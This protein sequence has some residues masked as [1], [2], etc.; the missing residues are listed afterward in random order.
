MSTQKGDEPILQGEQPASLQGNSPTLQRN[1]D[2]SL[3]RHPPTLRLAAI[4]FG[5]IC[6]LWLTHVYGLFFFGTSAYFSF[7]D[8]ATLSFKNIHILGA[9]VRLLLPVVV[10]FGLARLSNGLPLTEATVSAFLGA[11]L[12]CWPTI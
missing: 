9:A 1:D 12:L 11:L 3:M 5:T 2:P 4:F 6:L 7:N 8:L 10:G